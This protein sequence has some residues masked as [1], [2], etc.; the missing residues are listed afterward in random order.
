MNPNYDS[1]IERSAF[2]R[3]EVS[4][5][6][7]LDHSWEAPMFSE[8]GGWFY[9]NEDSGPYCPDCGLRGEINE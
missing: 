6:C 9:S 2:R 1:H 5:R 8:Y 4:H 3:E 7:E